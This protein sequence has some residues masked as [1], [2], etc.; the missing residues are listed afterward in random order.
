[1]R[2][3][4]RV[5]I[6]DPNPLA[7][8]ALTEILSSRHELRVLGAAA[9]PSIASRRAAGLDP[10]VFILDLEKP[11]ADSLPAL[12][13]MRALF[14][15]PAVFYTS[16]TEAER[17]RAESYAALANSEMFTKPATGLVQGISSDVEVLCDAIMRLASVA[18]GQPGA[19]R[20]PADF[21]ASAGPSGE[22]GRLLKNAGFKSQITAIGA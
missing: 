21:S 8:K 13:S 2:D 15:A 12:Q 5:F 20:R 14:P 1:M 17:S 10:E 9:T 19:L 18:R 16:L 11:L 22:G 3:P 4:V 6:V 7:R